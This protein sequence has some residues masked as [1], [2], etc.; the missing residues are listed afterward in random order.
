MRV[1]VSTRSRAKHKQSKTSKVDKKEKIPKDVREKI[2]ADAVAE[3]DKEEESGLRKVSATDEIQRL[4]PG[5]CRIKNARQPLFP[6]LPKEVVYSQEDTSEI[7]A[8]EQ[9]MKLW[10]VSTEVQKPYDFDIPEEESTVEPQVVDEQ[11][12]EV[13]ITEQ[14]EK[15]ADDPFIGKRQRQSGSESESKKRRLDEQDIVM[16]GNIPMTKQVV[17]ILNKQK[18]DEMIAKVHESCKTS[19]ARAPHEEHDYSQK[20][21]DGDNGDTLP[22]LAGEV[23]VT[24]EDYRKEK[25]IL[26]EKSL[27]QVH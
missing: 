21:P 26:Q 24:T 2:L 18:E 6:S 1:N 12:V 23:E 13:V 22:S 14:P 5:G 15:P 27:V 4:R 10:A 9:S 7:A 20:G 16:Y 11:A 3:I 25:E 17:D 8:K 19:E